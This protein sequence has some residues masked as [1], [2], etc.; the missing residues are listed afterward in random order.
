MIILLLLLCL[1]W[2]FYSPST[3][4][5][6]SLFSVY[7]LYNFINGSINYNYGLTHQSAWTD[8][9]CQRWRRCGVGP[10]DAS[11]LGRPSPPRGCTPAATCRGWQWHRRGPSRSVG[12][13]KVAVS[14][15][16]SLI[17]LGNTAYCAKWEGPEY[18]V[19]C[20]KTWL[21]HSLA[22]SCPHVPYTICFLSF[23]HEFSIK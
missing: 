13:D 3:T 5:V 6:S 22:A 2:T 20:S 11:C 17:C 8:R 18:C 7:V 10:P 21:S 1:C 23:V 15:V 4:S 14:A 16:T 12:N 9:H 19:S